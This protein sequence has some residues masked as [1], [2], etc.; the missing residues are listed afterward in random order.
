MRFESIR[1]WQKATLEKAAE[2]EN[3]TVIDLLI[4]LLFE[5]DSDNY[6]DF[7]EEKAEKYKYILEEQEEE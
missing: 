5:W 7:I 1:E 2:E 4:D 6:L 3:T